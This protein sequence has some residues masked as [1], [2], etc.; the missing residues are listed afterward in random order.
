[1][2]DIIKVADDC[3]V[4]FTESMVVRGQKVVHIGMGILQIEQRNGT[5]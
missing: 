3:H 1:M 4:I 5:H 2:N